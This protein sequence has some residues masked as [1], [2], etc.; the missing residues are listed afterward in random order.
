MYLFLLVLLYLFVDLLVWRGL[1]PGSSQLT[2]TKQKEFA[3]EWAGRSEADRAEAVK[4]VAADK[5]TAEVLVGGE[6]VRPPTAH[7]WELRWRAGTYLAPRDL[8]GQEAA[9]A[10]VPEK[11]T[12]TVEQPRLGVLSFVTRE[13]NRWSGRFVGWVASWN[14][15]MWRPG[16]DGSANV[17]YL[18]GLFV[19]AFAIAAI[20]GVLVNALTYFAAAATLDIVTRLRRAIY[21]HTYR[22]GSLAVRTA[23]PG[24]PAHLFTKQTDMVGSAIQA[25]LMASFYCPIMVFGLLVVILL[26]NFWLAVSFLLLAALVWVIGGQVAAHFRREARL[27]T[28]QGASALALLTESLGLIRLVK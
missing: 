17:P 4:R 8:V 3:T 15:W 11:P 12:A 26:V 5:A 16:A 13:R 28:R 14:G 2:A 18:T 6:K 1:V 23:G 9:D 21:L 7:E 22:L 27:G 19:F 24:E 20:R 25:W 10:Y